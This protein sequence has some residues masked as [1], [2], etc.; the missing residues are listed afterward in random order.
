MAEEITTKLYHVQDNSDIEENVLFAARKYYAQGNYTEA[1]KL[2]LD[3]TNK[4]VSAD[5]FVDIG[6][7][8]YML[9]GQ[10]EAL[11]Y[12]NKA[13]NLEPKHAKAYTNL[14]NLH[15]KNNQTEM[16][17]SYWL[18]ALISKPEDAKTSLNLAIAFD[19]KGMRFESIKY[20]EK[21]IKYEEEKHSEEY[22]K[23]KS[24]LQ[25]CF[26]VA[27]QYLTHGV[28]C[29]SE[30]DNKTAAACYFKSL[31]NYPNLSKTNLNLG[32]IFFEDKNLELAIKYWKTAG[33]IDPN[34][35]KIYS[36]LAI[37]YDLMEKF[38]YAYCYYYQYMNLNIKNKDEY[39]KTNKRVLKIKTYLNTHKDLI[40]AHLNRAKDHLAK[41]EIYEAIDEFKNYSILKPEEAKSYKDLIK[42]LESYFNPELEIIAN[43]FEIGNNLIKEKKFSEA[44]HY[45][46]RIMKLSSPQY[47]E[48]SKAKAKYSQCE[49]AQVGMIDV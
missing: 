6:N 11:E 18:V 45:F 44:K 33:Y 15:Y 35:D 37:S 16:A 22:L 30:G 49:K 39:Y 21:Y 25:H 14:G 48:Y 43:C 8:Y 41:N 1:L 4:T 27:S 47:L 32:S 7:C 28:K 3:T 19:K 5:I 13:I 42:K 2:L 46:W 9:D 29:Q 36:N 17:I 24:N 38:D 26:E 40:E 10:K 34:Y 23:V 31:A 20:F 12:W